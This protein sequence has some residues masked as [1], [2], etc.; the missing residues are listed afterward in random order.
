[1]KLLI[2]SVV[3]LKRGYDKTALKEFRLYTTKSDRSL[4]I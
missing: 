3:P 2:E 4:Q 1:M